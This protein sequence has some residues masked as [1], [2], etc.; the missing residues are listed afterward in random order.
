MGSQLTPWATVLYHFHCFI[1]PIRCCVDH[2]HHSGVHHRTIRKVSLRTIDHL[3]LGL[4][5]CSVYKVV[6]HTQ[7]WL[8]RLPTGKGE[9][10]QTRH[11][12]IYTVCKGNRL[13]HFASPLRRTQ[14]AFVLAAITFLNASMYPEPPSISIRATAFE[15]G[16]YQKLN[17]YSL[18]CQPV[19]SYECDHTLTHKLRRRDCTGDADTGATKPVSFAL[20]IQP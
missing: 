1:R 10:C 4:I 20:S 12:H 6:V 8:E 15:L 11:T 19:I 3:W 5:R 2:H 17:S 13:T 18:P 9:P 7:W 16:S 14:T